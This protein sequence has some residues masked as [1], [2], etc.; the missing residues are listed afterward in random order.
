MAG[1]IRDVYQ[2]LSTM[3]QCSIQ[4]GS[5]SAG[6]L[7]TKVDGGA[8]AAEVQD[9]WAEDRRQV[10][11][12]AWC[13]RTN[14]DGVDLNRNWGDQH[15]DAVHDV[16][17]DE[18]NP[19]PR[20]FS[21]PES[22]LLQALAQEERPDLFVSVHSGAY[23]LGTPYGYTRSKVPTGAAA[24]AEL[25][26]PISRDHCGGD[27]PYGDL[28]ELI[29]YDSMG[30]DIDWVMEHVGTPYVY[31]WEIYVGDAIRQGYIEQ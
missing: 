5:C 16:P 11:S 27:C 4:G 13:K 25:L 31:T 17:G 23:L 15:R 2:S 3:V 22:Q 29:H 24:M 1:S 6:R 20:G 26:G 14:E 10:E 30:C 19:G 28:A 7:H 18:M 21:E 12:G 9:L 8:P